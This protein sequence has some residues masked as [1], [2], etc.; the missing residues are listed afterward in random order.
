MDGSQMHCAKWKKPDPKDHLLYESHLYE[1]LE[2]AK[3]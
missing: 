1:L 2:K 3:L